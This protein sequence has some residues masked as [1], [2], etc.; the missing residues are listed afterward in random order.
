MALCY[1]WLHSYSTRKYKSKYHHMSIPIIMLTVV[2]DAQ[3]AYG[4]GV[5]R[6]ISKPFEP[7]RIIDEINDLV[8]QQGAAK[9]SIV[10]GDIGVRL[11]SLQ[12]ALTEVNHS[13][14]LAKDF[15]AFGQLAKEYPPRLVLVFDSS[16]QNEA[17][18]KRILDVLQDATVMVW[19]VEG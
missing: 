2:D 4:L 14:H 7:Q 9:S 8:Q 1:S 12:K 18:R 11:E 13:S 17:G 6:Y 3:R 5:E 19:F 10:L 15:A 16:L